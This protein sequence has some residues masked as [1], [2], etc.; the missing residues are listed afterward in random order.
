VKQE[1]KD[2]KKFIAVIGYGGSGKS[3][4]IRSISGAPATRFKND[5]IVD[6]STHNS[7][8]VFPNSPQEDRGFQENEFRSILE[9]VREQNQCSG[10]IMAIQPIRPYRQNEWKS[11]ENILRIIQD[12]D[13]FDIFAFLLSPPRNGEEVDV[14]GI[15]YRLNGLGVQLQEPLLD[16]RRFAHFNARLIQEIT[17]IIVG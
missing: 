10:I 8:Y 3:T 13:Y 6:I 15:Q 11:M 17:G 4:I 5:F 9:R 12:L 14:Q 16:A 7:V 2:K 1:S